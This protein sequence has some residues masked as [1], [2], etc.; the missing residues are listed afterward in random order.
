MM[1][2]WF[3]YSRTVKKTTSKKA[4]LQSGRTF[5]EVKE[6]L[7]KS[8]YAAFRAKFASG[9][10][11]SRRKTRVF[12]GFSTKLGTNSAEKLLWLI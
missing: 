1:G 11:K 10:A 9:K 3:R 6:F 4:Y 12:Q 7:I 2:F 8:R 5:L